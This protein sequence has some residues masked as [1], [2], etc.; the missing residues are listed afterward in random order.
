MGN[1]VSF[2]LGA[3]SSSGSSLPTSGRIPALLSATTGPAD[4]AALA[5]S[6][7]IPSFNAISSA[8][9][10]TGSRPITVSHY[11]ITQ[12]PLAFSSRQVGY[13]GD[14]GPSDF[15]VPS[16]M[17]ADFVYRLPDFGNRWTNGF[18]VSGIFTAQN[19]QPFSIFSGPAYGQVA[20][21]ISVGVAQTSPIHTTGNPTGYFSGISHFNLAQ[22][23]NSPSCPN[24]YAKGTVLYT[25]TAPAL[26]QACVGNSAR[27]SFRGPSYI[28]QDFAI[29]KTTRVHGES[30][31]VIVR[32]EFFNLFNRANYYNPISEYSLD[33]VHVNPEFGLVRSAHDPLQIQF[34]VRYAF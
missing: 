24:L 17:V 11:N 6:A 33:G 13:G 7:N 21:R 31:N 23:A 30:Q 19:G 9:T 28:N 22:S 20:Q 14:Y 26:P 34:A 3:G 18:L 1:P 12:S 15:D 27:N 5:N 8:L 32:A 16:R 25:G 10:T 29:Q 4:R 2:A